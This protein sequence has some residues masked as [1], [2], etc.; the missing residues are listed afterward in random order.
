MELTISENAECQQVKILLVGGAKL[1]RKRQVRTTK[2]QPFW[3]TVY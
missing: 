3:P 2:N 1:T